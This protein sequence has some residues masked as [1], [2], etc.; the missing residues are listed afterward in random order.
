MEDSSIIPTI[1]QVKPNNIIKTRKNFRNKISIK[2]RIRNSMLKK[3]QL[4]I[5]MKWKNKQ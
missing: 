2:K 3:K 5:L 1:K 4:K